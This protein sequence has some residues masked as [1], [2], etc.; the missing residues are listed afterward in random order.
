[1]KIKAV[2]LTDGEHYFIHGSDSE[3]SAE[4][5]KAMQ[6]IWAYDPA[7]ESAHFVELEVAI[8]DFEVTVATDAN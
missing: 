3:T 1:M 2:I 8:P 7:T 5:F 6:P 4:M